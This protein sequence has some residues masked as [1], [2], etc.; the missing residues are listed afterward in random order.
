MRLTL[1]DLLI[2]GGLFAI[3]ALAGART[4]HPHDDPARA[5]FGVFVGAV[6]ILVVASPIYRRLHFRPLWFPHCPHCRQRPEHY[7]IAEAG[8]GWEVVACGE[9]GGIVQLWYARESPPAD[10]DRTTPL[11]RLRWPYFLGP[12]RAG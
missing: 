2:L 1:I 5:V 10:R 9:C 12:W 4:A 3:G 7:R 8:R 6:T 11:L